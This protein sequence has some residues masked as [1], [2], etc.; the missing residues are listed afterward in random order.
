MHDRALDAFK[1]LKRSRNQFRTGLRQHLNRDV[2]RDQMFVN[3]P[4]H[5]IEVRLRGRRKSNFNLFEPDVDQQLK[6]LQLL[7]DVHRL[8]QRLVTVPQIHTAP[9]RRLFNDF[10]RPGALLEASRRVRGVFTMIEGIHWIN[11]RIVH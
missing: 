2:I 6:Q 1:R 8:N 9:A 4:A 7:G 11:S 3:Q 5:E 10:V